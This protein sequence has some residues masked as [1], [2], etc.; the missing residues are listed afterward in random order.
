[1]RA[2]LKSYKYRGV[3]K[4]HLSSGFKNCG[5]KGL[6]TKKINTSPLREHAHTTQMAC[7]FQL[8]AFFHLASL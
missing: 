1:M 4:K 5:T 8:D 6:K 3:Y 2:V 7:G